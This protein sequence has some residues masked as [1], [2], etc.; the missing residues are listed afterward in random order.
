MVCLFSRPIARG[1]LWPPYGFLHGLIFYPICLPWID[2]VVQ[3]YGNVG[4]WT[5]AGLLLLLVSVAGGMI[6]AVFTW[7]VAFAS[8][9][10]RRAAFA[11]ALAP[12]LWVTIEFARAHLPI[13]GFP[14]NLAGY[15]AS[16][17]LALVQL[18]TV[19]GIY[20]LS[21]VVAGYGSLVA[22]AVL[23][24]RQ[25][26]WKTVLVVT[27]ALILIALGGELSRAVGR[28]TPRFMAHLVQT[29]FAQSYEYQADWMTEHAGDLDELE[30]YQRGRRSTSRLPGLIVWPEAPAPFSMEDPLFAV[31]AQQIA[32]DSRGDFLVGAEDWR[33]DAAGKWD[34]DEQRHPAEPVRRTRIFTYDKIHLVPFGEYVPLRRWLTFAGKLTAD[35]GDFTPRR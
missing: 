7:G 3:Q 8:R 12:F 27:G 35:I 29:N 1:R 25:R 11:C 13:F 32:R 24:G 20:G 30:Q 9:Q 6:V 23:V 28:P 2:V 10:K 15:A 5:S 26:V 16:S 22:Y 21:F 4:F 34:R 14:W 18:T 19:T 31:R 33:R 17:N